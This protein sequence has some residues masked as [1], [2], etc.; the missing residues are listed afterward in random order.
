MK[1]AK[2]YRET[3]VSTMGEAMQEGVPLPYA[4]VC[5][6]MHKAMFDADHRSPMKMN[7]TTRTGGLRY[8]VHMIREA[9]YCSDKTYKDVKGYGKVR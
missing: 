5:W 8:I 4:Q 6:N 7:L 1:G 2:I 9:A 3:Y